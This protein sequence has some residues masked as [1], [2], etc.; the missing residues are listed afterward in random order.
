MR[1][2]ESG[3]RSVEHAEPLRK[4]VTVVAQP[5]LVSIKQYPVESIAPGSD[6]SIAL[7][8]PHSNA[9]NCKF[10]FRILQGHTVDNLVHQR[11]ALAAQHKIGA[12]A[13]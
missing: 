3:F 5:R 10:K 1:D 7:C 9:L 4:P 6:L 2:S 11:E 13:G 12:A 8:A